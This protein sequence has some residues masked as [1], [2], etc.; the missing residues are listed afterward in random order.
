MCGRFVRYYICDTG[1]GSSFD[2]TTTCPSSSDADAG[3]AEFTRIG[4]FKWKAPFC[5]FVSVMAVGG[6]SGG[7][8]QWSSGKVHNMHFNI[9]P[10]FQNGSQKA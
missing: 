10:L 3:Q 4:T 2:C 5:G 7:G 6:G 1:Q 8:Y 9:A